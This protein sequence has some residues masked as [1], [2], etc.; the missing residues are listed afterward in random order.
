MP[1]FAQ[2]DKSGIFS[3][4]LKQRITFTILACC[5]FLFTIS[6]LTKPLSAALNPAQA[7]AASSAPT[8]A[9]PNSAQEAAGL[10]TGEQ[11]A[12]NYAWAPE[13][14]YGIISSPQAGALD[15]LYDAAFAAGP[16]IVPQLEAALQDDRTAEFA[17]QSLAF[18]GGENAL[19]ALSKLVR[20]P[21]SLDLSRFFYGALGEVNTAGANTVLLN[22]VRNANS[23]PDRTVTEAAIIALT[24][25]NRVELVP[26]LKQAQAKLT[27]PVIQDDLENATSII[28]AR[29]KYLA[30]LPGRN[31]GG[32]LQQALN[33]YFEPAL[34]A[35]PAPRHAATA[36]A[37]K[38][39]IQHLEFSTDQSRALARV[40]FDDQGAKAYYQIVLQKRYGDWTVASV[41]LSLEGEKVS[42]GTNPAPRPGSAPVK[43]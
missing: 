11:P 24:V 13:L 27:D 30:A 29:A 2:H 39:E 15:S 12:A 42:P 10:E 23:Q 43:R 32:S 19:T 33:L 37:A 8:R 22:A 38:V 36:P 7:G 28:Q 21:R 1:R 5:V 31:A 14:L 40:A 26:Q 18:I 4:Q 17:A 6:P 16:A 9:A 25:H 41:W 3:I 34:A 20:D 35:A